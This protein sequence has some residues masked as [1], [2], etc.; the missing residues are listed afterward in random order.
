M[1]LVENTL[2]FCWQWTSDQFQYSKCCIGMNGHGHAECWMIDFLAEFAGI[3]HWR[4]FEDCVTK[5]NHLSFNSCIKNNKRDQ[6]YYPWLG[7]KRL[8]Y[9]FTTLSFYGCLHK[10]SKRAYM[11]VLL[12]YILTALLEYIN[13]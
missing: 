7:W 5:Y 6:E 12:E 13:F 2:K 8:V 4:R 10:C 11:N 3:I 9:S 1:R